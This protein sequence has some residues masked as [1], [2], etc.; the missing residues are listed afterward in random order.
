MHQETK[1]EL[2][3]IVLDK[4]TRIEENTRAV[5]RELRHLRASSHGLTAREEQILEKMI[6]E[7]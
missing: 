2:L 6:E 5:A 1:D 7:A 3:M 4:L